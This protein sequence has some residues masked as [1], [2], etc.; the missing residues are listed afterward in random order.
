MIIIFDAY[1]GDWTLLAWAFAYGMH[2]AQTQG[3]QMIHLVARKLTKC[4]DVWDCALP[5]RFYTCGETSLFR[6]RQCRCLPMPISPFWR[7]GGTA[8]PYHRCH[9]HRELQCPMLGW[10]FGIAWEIQV[11]KSEDML[12][13]CNESMRSL[14]ILRGAIQKLGLLLKTMHD[15][16]R[17]FLSCISK[18]GNRLTN[19]SSAVK[20]LQFNAPSLVPSLDG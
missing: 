3:Y 11:T 7:M 12:A 16:A 9:P 2:L 6:C 20:F 8:K 1:E 4:Y 5:K 14:S 19:Y 17:E 15:T 13:S 18:C 10:H